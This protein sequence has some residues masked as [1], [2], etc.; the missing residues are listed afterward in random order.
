MLE[1]FGCSADREAHNRHGGFCAS[2]M[3]KEQMKDY[4]PTIFTIYKGKLYL[5]STPEAMQES[6]RP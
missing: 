1:A 2:N 6:L 3:S 5:C 4:D